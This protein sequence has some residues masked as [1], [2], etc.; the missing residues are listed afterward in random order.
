[1]TD[2][3]DSFTA[4]I[5]SFADKE[6]HP[7]LRMALLALAP[8]IAT[9]VIAELDLDQEW[10]V[11]TFVKRDGDRWLLDDILADTNTRDRA[12][13]SLQSY[14]QLDRERSI[15]DIENADFRRAIVTRWYRE[16][17][18]DVQ[19]VLDDRLVE[20]VQNDV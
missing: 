18:E 3:N 8:A 16:W 15:D 10:A 9:H 7:E 4:A 17:Q 1:M 12:V 2:L 5:Q 11:G 19:P 20:L 14:R 13:K 6:L